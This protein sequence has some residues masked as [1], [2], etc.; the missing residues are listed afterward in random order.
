MTIWLL[1]HLIA[2]SL[3][4]RKESEEVKQVEVYLFGIMI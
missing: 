2:V 4:E 1:I 3:I